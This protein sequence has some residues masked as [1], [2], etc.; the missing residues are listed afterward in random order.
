MVGLSFW[1][2]VYTVVK[3][4]DKPVGLSWYVRASVYSRHL[5]REVSPPKKKTY[6]SPRKRLP[7]GVQS[8]ISKFFQVS[9]KRFLTD[10]F[11]YGQ[12][13]QKIIRHFAIKVQIYA[14]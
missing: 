7:N 6:N 13:T 10:V 8:L 1:L 4:F 14:P 11:F 12:Q 5:F 9:C 2:M 3:L